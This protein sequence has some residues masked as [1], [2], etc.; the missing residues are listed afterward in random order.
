M[1]LTPDQLRFVRLHRQEHD[2]IEEW[3][4]LFGGGTIRARTNWGRVAAIC[5]P[6]LDDLICAG[7]LMKQCGGFYLTAKGNAL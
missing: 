3:R 5:K 2:Y 6:M 7:L 4:E 1:T